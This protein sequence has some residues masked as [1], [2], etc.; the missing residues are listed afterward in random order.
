MNDPN[1]F[2]RLLSIKLIA[3]TCVAACYLRIPCTQGSVRR[4]RGPQA[5]LA[6]SDGRDRRVVGLEERLKLSRL[7]KLFLVSSDVLRAALRTFPLN[8]YKLVSTAIQ[9][10]SPMRVMQAMGGGN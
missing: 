1:A 8:S 2:A 3:E 5:P 9:I 7:Q 10:I 4:R 6:A